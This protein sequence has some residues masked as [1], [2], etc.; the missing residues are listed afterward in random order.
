MKR[1][2]AIALAASLAAA[3]ASRVK[4]LA[5]I[6][7]VRD[8]P[9]VGYGLVVG[10]AGTGDKRQTVFSAQSL[11]N[12]LERMGVSVPPAAMLVRNMAAVMVTANLPPFAEPGTRIGVLVA[13][14]GDATNLQ[15]GMLLMTSL[16]GA[17]G[18]VYA[19]AQGPV[20]TGGFVAGRGGTSQTVNH[21]TAGR[22]PNGAIVERRPPSPAPGAN[23]RLQLLR[24]DF[25]TAARLAEAINR[26]FGAQGM[27]VARAETPSLVSVETP[28]AYAGKTV[29]YIAAIEALTLE[30]DR[31]A[32]I[33][34]NE[35][36][37]TV[38]FGKEVRV[39][40]VSILH[41]NLSVDIQTT[42]EVSQPAP[43]AA[44]ETVVTPKASV[45]VKEEQARSVTLKEG[46]TIDDV[47]RAL[48]AI[49]STP[50]DII[51]ILENLR[52]AGALDAE[53]E[54]I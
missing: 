20:V 41:G 24:A 44:G 53:L 43:L 16:R 2:P 22:I 25:T 46:A 5:A 3:G 51:A 40:A 38:V 36:T 48:M 27:P 11:A 49:G 13:A 37:G 35:R 1:I 9:L 6:E 33:V 26:K 15:G 29:E 7:G 50:R 39:G 52:A 54:V 47:V 28:P 45:G 4:D 19:V 12:M 18:Q 42:L 31:R 34:V 10:L 32:R 8:N 21:P 30:P 14:M 17:D 23:L